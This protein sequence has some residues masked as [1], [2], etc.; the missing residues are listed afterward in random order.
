M[1]QFQ[2]LTRK[3]FL[4]FRGH[5]VHLEQRQMSKFLVRYQQFASHAYC[6]AAGPVF[7]MASQQEKALSATSSS[8]PCTKLTLHCNH[9]FG[10]LKTEHA[11]SLT[12]TYNYSLRNSSE[13]RISDFNNVLEL[14]TSV[15]NRCCIASDGRTS[16]RAV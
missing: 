6:G 4:T 8:K 7:K 15:Y 10:H 16:V 14:C 3:I 13:E 2:K 5:N 9:R 1:V 11:E 12:T